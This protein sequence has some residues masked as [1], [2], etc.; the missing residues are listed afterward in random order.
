MTDVFERASDKENQDREDAI[1]AVVEAARPVTIATGVC[2]DCLEP[3][4]PERLAVAP[5]AVRCISCQQDDDKRYRM[6]TGGHRA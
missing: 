2:R 4:E 5:Y 6:M 1:A 3:I